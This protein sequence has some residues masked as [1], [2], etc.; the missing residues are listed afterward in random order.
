MASI[1]KNKIER[2]ITDVLKTAIIEKE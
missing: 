1:N 2:I